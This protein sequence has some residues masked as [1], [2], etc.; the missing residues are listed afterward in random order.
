MNCRCELWSCS[1]RALTQSLSQSKVGRLPTLLQ[2]KIRKRGKD[3]AMQALQAYNYEKGISLEPRV[4][5]SCPQ[6]REGGQGGGRGPSPPTCLML[7]LLLLAHP[8]AKARWLN[9][10]HAGPIVPVL[11]GLTVRGG[12]AGCTP[13]QPPL[14]LDQ[15]GWSP[16][17]PPHAPSP[18]RPLPPCFPAKHV[19][20]KARSG[21]QALHSPS[22]SPRPSHL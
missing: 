14:P 22:P 2:R 17:P 15:R 7:V 8:L 13:K 9:M 1:P 21:A 20:S 11:P 5:C 3:Q 18:P 16:L 4:Q 6:V 10:Q 12:C 19:S